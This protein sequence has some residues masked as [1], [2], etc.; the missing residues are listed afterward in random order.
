M[1]RIVKLIVI[2]LLVCLFG[3]P[4][5]AHKLNA[6]ETSISYNQRTKNL[7]IVHRFFMHDVNHLIQAYY[8][9]KTDKPL[10]GVDETLFTDYIIE[11]TKLNL[12][13]KNGEKLTYSYIGSE[14]DGKHYFI[15]QEV[16]SNLVKPLAEVEID[17]TTMQNK[18]KPKYWLFNIS[19]KDKFQNSFVLD[20]NS[21]KKALAL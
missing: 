18:W 19:L 12:I 2:T 6:A 7:E 16:S 10:E 20:S 9:N 13:D 8:K 15:Y 4:A 5:L 21:Y 17:V 3:K 1:M 11:N 14:Q